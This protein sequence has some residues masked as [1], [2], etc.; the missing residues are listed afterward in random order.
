MIFIL[1]SGSSLTMT[2]ERSMLL[3]LAFSIYWLVAHFMVQ[4]LMYHHRLPSPASFFESQDAPGKSLI[5]LRI[6][7]GLSLTLVVPHI[8]Y[9][10]FLGLRNRYLYSDRSER[11][12]SRY[13]WRCEPFLLPSDY[14]PLHS[15]LE[16]LCSTGQ[17]IWKTSGNTTFLPKKSCFF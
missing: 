3:E 15:W 13:E 6:E 14:I 4:L 16:K 10:L 8:F 9:G 17:E 5:S 1:L 12:H 7:N 11:R 2:P